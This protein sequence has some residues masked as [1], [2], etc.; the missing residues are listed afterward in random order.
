MIRCRESRETERVN[1]ISKLNI[2]NAEWITE[3]RGHDVVRT[4][5]QPTNIERALATLTI[6]VGF[7]RPY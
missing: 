1:V 6:D 7:Y 2:A 4:P 5:V 3:G